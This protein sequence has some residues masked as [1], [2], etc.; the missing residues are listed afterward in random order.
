L[1][2][3]IQVRADDTLIQ[4][5]SANVLHAVESVLVVVIFNKAETTRGL[6]ESVEAHDKPL[7]LATSVR[8]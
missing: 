2:A 5:G 4:L 1:E 7:D 3:G 6:L 8:R